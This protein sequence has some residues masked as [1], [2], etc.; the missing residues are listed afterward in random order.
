MTE[1]P[2]PARTCKESCGF[3]LFLNA[4]ISIRPHDVL[5]H[6]LT[7]GLMH[8]APLFYK[9]ELALADLKYSGGYTITLIGIIRP[10]QVPK[11][12]FSQNKVTVAK[13]LGTKLEEIPLYNCFVFY[14]APRE[15]P[16]FSLTYDWIDC[17]S[18]ERGVIL[19]KNEQVVA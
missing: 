3:L 11:Y 14:T 9:G 19:W 17:I 5:Q 6:T 12:L 4:C 13:G 18:D 15:R 16:H 2:T 8:T 10:I 1:P 7:Y